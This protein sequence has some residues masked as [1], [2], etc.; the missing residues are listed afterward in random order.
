MEDWGTVAASAGV[1]AVISAVVSLLTIH[2]VTVRRARAERAD[3]SR[4]A[5]RK[6]VEPLL[7]E[8]ARYQYFGREEPK[9]TSEMS[10]MQDHTYLVQVRAAAT[11]LSGF[12]R[13]LVDRRC[14]RTFGGYWTDLAIDLPTGANDAGTFSAW[15]ASGLKDGQLKTGEG[16]LDGLVHRAYSL[17][18]GHELQK[19]LRRNLKRLAACR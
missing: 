11:D 2:Q 12:R 16:P 10:H 15:L 7:R 4:Q 17:P 14:R 19:K 13:W 8:L 18:P 3:A 5:V 1:S 6:A 9:R